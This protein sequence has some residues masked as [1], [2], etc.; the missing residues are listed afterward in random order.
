MELVGELSLDQALKES[1]WG[2]G[3]HSFQAS[4]TGS[5]KLRGQGGLT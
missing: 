1:C 2:K 4:D 3:G 5:C